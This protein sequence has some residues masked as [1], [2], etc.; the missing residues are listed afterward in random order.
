MG[1]KDFCQRHSGGILTGC[2]I[3]GSIATGYFGYRGGLKARRLLEERYDAEND[4][5][6]PRPEN[7]MAYY[8]PK[9]VIKTT[10]KA[11]GPAVGSCIFTIVS[12]AS[13]RCIDVK[14][15]RDISAVA[16][17]AQLTTD[18]FRKNV[19]EKFGEEKAREIEAQTTAEVVQKVNPR[20]ALPSMPTPSCAN[21]NTYVLANNPNII[22]TMTPED[23]QR[24]INDLNAQIVAGVGPD[25]EEAKA[26]SYL[27]YN[28]FLERIGA[29]LISD[30]WDRGWP[31]I[32]YAKG[33]FI[34]EQ[35][36]PEAG[37]FENGASY[38]IFNFHNGP[39]YLDDPHVWKYFC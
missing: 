30:G 17:V 20:P 7:L 22:F 5:M 18:T 8:G 11:W 6:E 1:I 26:G 38:T 27:P 19:A 39:F 10:W 4:P 14:A 28:A 23:L 21:E 36:T 33:P 2:A 12:I 31:C 16:N 29:Q 25:I 3:I 34:I 37:C 32:E 24:E 15:I 9:E 13:L 35:G